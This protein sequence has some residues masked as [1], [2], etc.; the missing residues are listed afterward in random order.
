MQNNTSGYATVLFL[1]CQCASTLLKSNNFITFTLQ[2]WTSQLPLLL[3]GTSTVLLANDPTWTVC[4]TPQSRSATSDIKPTNKCYELCLSEN[5]KWINITNFF[6][7]E[8]RWLSSSLLVV[9]LYSLFS[10]VAMLMFLLPNERDNVGW[11]VELG[12]LDDRALLEPQSGSEHRTTGSQEEQHEQED[13]EREEERVEAD[14]P[15]SWSTRK[16]EREGKLFFHMILNAQQSFL[17]TVLTWLSL[18][19]LSE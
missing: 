5:G 10:Y 9:R 11:G 18:C 19:V 3:C 4:V 13:D 12:V 6:S 2:N 1:S 7:K 15:E 14:F 8:N 16:R 17:T